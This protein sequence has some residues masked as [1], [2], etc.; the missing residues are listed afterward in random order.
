MRKQHIPVESS[1]RMVEG[2]E[3][4]SFD[5]TIVRDEEDEELI[6]SSG[7]SRLSSQAPN[8]LASADR[9]HSA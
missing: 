5:T 6:L 9:N 2:G 3:N 8:R 1:W 4:D 7:V